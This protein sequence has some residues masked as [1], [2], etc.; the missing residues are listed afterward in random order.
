MTLEANRRKQADLIPKHT[1]W[2]K[3]EVQVFTPTQ[4]SVKLKGGDEITYD[5]MVLAMGV[6]LRFDM[7]SSFFILLSNF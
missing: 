5:F 1:S 2:I 6:Q 3:D 7:V 4:N